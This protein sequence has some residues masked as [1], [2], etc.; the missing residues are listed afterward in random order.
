MN[1]IFPQMTGY[2]LLM[3]DELKV[4]S[5]EVSHQGCSNKKMFWKSAANLEE[6]IHAEVRFQ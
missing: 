2:D 5:S 6:N 3:V 4:L 1:T